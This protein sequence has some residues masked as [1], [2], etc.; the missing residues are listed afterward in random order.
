MSDNVIRSEQAVYR[1]AECCA[2]VM[3]LTCSEFWA[4]ECLETA[5]L[6]IILT[7]GACERQTGTALQKYPAGHSSTETSGPRA[8]ALVPPLALEAGAECGEVATHTSF[9][10]RASCDWVASGRPGNLLLGI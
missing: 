10:K 8:S 1:R 7:L 4:P 2:G 3:P 9:S 5:M 6:K